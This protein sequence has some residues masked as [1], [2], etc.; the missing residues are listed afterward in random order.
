MLRVQS[1]LPESTCGCPNERLASFHESKAT[2]GRLRIL[3]VTNMWPDAERPHWGTF[4]RSQ[5]QSLED[6][7]VRVD[8]LVIRG[9]ATP[10]AYFASMSELWSRLRTREYDVIHI[11]TGHA[12]A[13]SAWWV[14]RPAVV[15][16]VGGDLI[17][18]VHEGGIT[19][20]SQAEALVFRQLARA[21]TATIT[22]SREME[23]ALP[24]SVRR[25][26]AIIPNGVDLERFRPMPKARARRS[27]GWSP[28]EKIVLFLGNP[29][30]P[31]KNVA[32]AEDAV[33]LARDEAPALRL[34]KAFGVR[35][36]EIPT[37][38]SAADC[39]AFPSRSEG[40]PN[41]VKEAMAA[42][43]PIVATPVGDV[44]ERLT[45]V[46]GGF[47][48]PPAPAPFAEA[49]LGAI[50]YPR[51]PAAREAIKSLSLS[52]VAARVIDVY[53][54][55]MRSTREAARPRVGT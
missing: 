22:K 16:F 14:P 36:E 2:A 20:R 41:V 11:H 23:N 29:D 44:V 10:R 17:G 32:L 5:A 21:A 15:S 8:R 9:Y 12:A 28:D 30:D 19:P 3:F 55:A 37:M 51:A 34:H 13:I 27:L 18:N 43:L 48:A 7:D 35:P 50:S 33:G 45:G 39:L 40:S 52:A 49:L 25:R 54:F 53:E 42:A 24:R 6:A 26:N 47:V 31:R 46:E 1:F 4:I 38:M